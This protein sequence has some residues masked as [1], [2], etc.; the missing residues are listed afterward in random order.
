MT[1]KNWMMWTLLLIIPALMWTT[2]CSKKALKE[3]ASAQGATVDALAGRS[4]TGSGS[5]EQGSVGGMT[6]EQQAQARFLDEHIYF[7]FD[8]STLTQE[9]QAKLTEKADWLRQNAQVNV[10]IEGHCDERGTT[11]YN[12]ALGDR[13]AN[14]VKR[15]LINLGIA[16]NRMSTVSYGEERPINPGHD[17]SAWSLN[18]RAQFVL[19]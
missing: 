6:P 13:R 4:S 11:E 16:D 9:S 7:D 1:R 10:A 17:E 12:L 3:D 5:A 18:R 19:Q 8:S 14:S 2:G 15:F